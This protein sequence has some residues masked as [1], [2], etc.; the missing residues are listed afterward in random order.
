MQRVGARNTVA[1]MYRKLH[2]MKRP[3]IGITVD[4][5]ENTAASG[6]YDVGIGYGRAVSDAGGTP[7]LLPHE[8][9]CVETYA[10]LCDGLILTGGV[11]P[12]T[13]ALPTDWPGH[14]PLHPQA[15][16]MDPTRQAFELAML[17]AWETAKPDGA[18]LGVCLGMQLLTLRHGGVLN[19]YMPD[20]HPEE[21]VNR[22]RK[23]SHAI[24]VPVDDSVLQADSRL[25]VSHHQ[26]AIA[27]AGRL[28][29]VATAEDGIIEAVDDPSHPFRLGVQ[30]HPERGDDG[31]LSRGLIRRLVLAA[32]PT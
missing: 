13:S 10:A 19:Q 7:L 3:L 24:R 30:W 22:H 20:T 5:L 6:R 25:I 23:A 29:V 26:Q 32:S 14:A 21:V 11:D 8:L 31:P 17:E 16:R 12:D 9:T 28:R 1:E 4:N 2:G 27:D 15:R 18:V